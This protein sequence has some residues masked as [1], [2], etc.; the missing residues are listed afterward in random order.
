MELTGKEI[1]ALAEF[2][3][4]PLHPTVKM[5]EDEME[6]KITVYKDSGRKLAHVTDYP[7]EGSIDLNDF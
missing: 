6:T 4:V 1:H 5:S 7:E 2:V 3:G